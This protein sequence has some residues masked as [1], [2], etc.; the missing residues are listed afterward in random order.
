MRQ[1]PM[2]TTA[3][4]LLLLVS[5]SCANQ[6]QTDDNSHDQRLEFRTWT[7]ASGAYQTEA[8][9]VRYAA[10]FVVLCRSESEARRALA[11]L[12]E[13]TAGAG[14]TLHPQKTRL[15]DA[16]RKGGFDFLGYH[17]E[18]GMRWPS[19]KSTRRLRDAVRRKTRR[20]NGHSLRAI[21]RDVNHTLRGWSEHF[22][23]SIATALKT[24]DSWVRMRLRSILRKRHGGRGRGRG[25]GSQGC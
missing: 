2:Q 7:D 18:R 1:I 19:A 20:A 15:V 6:V 5:G 24:L 9:M 14:L 8:A 11:L 22:K 21:I 12:Q 10:D 13:W 3:L 16:T 25:L 17:F 4:I 23:H